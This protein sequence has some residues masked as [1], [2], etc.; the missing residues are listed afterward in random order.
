[1]TIIPGVLGGTVFCESEVSR[2][3]EPCGPAPL[4][5]TVA[6]EMLGRVALAA[7]SRVQP[8]GNEEAPPPAFGGGG[9]ET[10][11]IGCHDS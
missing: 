1:M 3:R 11:R 6:L 5:M 10:Y 4:G 7:S 8:S 2:L 9:D